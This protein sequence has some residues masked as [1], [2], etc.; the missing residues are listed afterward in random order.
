ML[1]SVEYNTGLS[2][3]GETTPTSSLPS[4]P[5]DIKSSL[6][7]SEFEFQFDRYRLFKT[8]NFYATGH[9]WDELSRNRKVC[10]GAQTSLDRLYWLL[11]TI[12]NWSGP[13]SISLFAPDV[14]YQASI[15]FISYLRRCF[16]SIRDQVSFHLTFPAA[17]PP[18][19]SEKIHEISGHMSC[20]EPKDV[21]SKLISK[22]ESSMLKWRETLEYPQNLLRNLAKN[23]CQTEFTFIPDIDMIPI[24]GL[25]EDLDAFLAEE[26]QENCD[27]CA[28][29]VPTYEIKVSL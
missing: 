6:V 16:P 12:E 13:I 28:F 21:L 9:K 18:S 15:L 26:E 29:V 4:L 20:Q 1:L 7:P 23:G 25:A 27:K 3:P 17:H 24:P 22:R 19:E 14:E 11:E 2:K 5:Y 10:L 8:R